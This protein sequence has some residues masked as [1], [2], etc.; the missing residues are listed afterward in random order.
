M[1]TDARGQ[2]LRALIVAKS[3]SAPNMSLAY[4]VTAAGIEWLEGVE[5]PP[6]PPGSVVD[7]TINNFQAYEG[8]AGDVAGGGGGG[9]GEQGPAWW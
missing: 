7:M 2:Q 6:I 9:G 1:N 3:P 4:Q 8:Q 5:P